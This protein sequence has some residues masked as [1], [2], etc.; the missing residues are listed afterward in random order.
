MDRIIAWIMIIIT[1]VHALLPV[2]SHG[3]PLDLEGYSLVFEDGFDG[4]TL[5]TD[6]W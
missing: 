6:V 1:A 3:A 2:V 4:E 5:D